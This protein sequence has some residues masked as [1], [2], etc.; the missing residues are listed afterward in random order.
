MFR[1]CLPA[2]VLLQAFL[3]Q[4]DTLPEPLVALPSDTANVDAAHKLCLRWASVGQ[5]AVV[6]PIQKMTRLMKTFATPE[7]SAPFY[8]G[9]RYCQ[10]QA[11]SQPLP[12]NAASKARVLCS[13]GLP[14]RS[15]GS[16]GS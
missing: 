7:P 12:L 8:P 14:S 5:V 3:W 11:T 9:V 2:F 1:A 10:A 6:H 16:S 4:R 15:R 13:D